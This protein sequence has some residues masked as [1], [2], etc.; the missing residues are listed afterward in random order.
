[1]DFI[2]AIE[3][4]ADG[5]KERDATMTLKTKVV[6]GFLLVVMFTLLVS[7]ISIYMIGKMNV[8]MKEINDNNVPLMLKTAKVATINIQQVASLRAFL[9]TGEDSYITDYKKCSDEAARI[10]DEL[11]KKAISEKG[12]N[13]ALELR[14]LD[15][16]YD[17]YVNRIIALKKA[18]K[19]QEA[20]AIMRDQATPIAKVLNTKVEEFMVFREDQIGNAF[21]QAE[22]AGNHARTV[23]GIIGLAALIVGIGIGIVISKM[24]VGALRSVTADL[25]RLAKGDYSFSVP[26]AS[27]AKRDEIGIMA[28]AM[29]DMLKAMRGIVGQISHSAELV[30]ASSEQLT[31]SSAEAAQAATQ[32]AGAITDVA[33]GSANQLKEVD[34]TTSIVEQLSTGIQDV[35][36]NA[37]NAAVMAQQTSTAAQEGGKAVHMAAN[38][39]AQIEK[40]VD[41]S[42]QL[43]GKLGERS[44]EI[45][46]IVDAISGIAGQTNLLALNA[47]IEAARA[48]EQGRG[49]A[50]VAEEVRKLAEQSQYAAKQIAEL[51]SEIREDTDKAVNAMNEGTREVKTG[52]EV[53]S[54]A[55]RTFGEIVN[56]IEQ[57]SDQVNGISAAIEQMAASSQHIVV[58]VQEIDQISKTASAHTQTVSAATEEQLASMEEIASS[59]QMLAKMAEE[60]RDITLK[61]KV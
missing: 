28:R 3:T 40:S 1:M 45:G 51:I 50:V 9:L 22:A 2:H 6:G 25:S 10:E 61:F 49:F 13:M 33:K 42:A 46:K 54:E 44:L 56:L 43:V 27:L 36:A 41:D 18:G 11:E 37:S 52:T 60:L 32:V 17:Q 16:E 5:S 15:S 23:T 29:D 59:S 20:I 8:T 39:M 47:A 21:A 7:G 38:Q 14:R 53:V 57:V 24:V 12:R 31:A 4:I 19:D 48:G 55:G 35:A 30:A 58:S 34:E 26:K